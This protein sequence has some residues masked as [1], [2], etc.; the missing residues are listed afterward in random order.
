MLYGFRAFKIEESAKQIGKY[1]EGLTRHL[2]SYDDYFK[3]VGNS[4]STTVNHY[5]SA[6]KEFGKIDKDVLKIT[7]ESTDIGIVL[8]DKPNKE[9]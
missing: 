9:E 3:K 8:I 2:K 7:G 4:L 5:N 1:V 6:S